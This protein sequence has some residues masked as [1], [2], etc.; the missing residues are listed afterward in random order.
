MNQNNINVFYTGCN[1][2]HLNKYLDLKLTMEMYMKLQME[3]LFSRTVNI[4][5]QTVPGD[6][7]SAKLMT[8]VIIDR[9]L[10][11]FI[12]GWTNSNIAENMQGISVNFMSI[13]P[14]PNGDV[15]A[16]G[17]TDIKPIFDNYIYQRK[18]NW[19]DK[20]EDGTEYTF[21]FEGVFVPNSPH[22]EIIVRNFV[23]VTTSQMNDNLGMDPMYY[24]PDYIPGSMTGGS[25][26]CIGEGCE[27]NCCKSDGCTCDNIECHCENK[28]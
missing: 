6:I 23:N 3:Y 25:Y 7:N 28:E 27:R 15:N 22:F 12:D 2:E 16:L 19:F 17:F 18:G 14:G 9:Q 20:I 13:N 21:E 8:T 10:I 24:D 11:D 1:I 4:N 26:S 5:M